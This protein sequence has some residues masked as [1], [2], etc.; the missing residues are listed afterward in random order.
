MDNAIDLASAY[1]HVHGYVTVAEYPIICPA[2]DAG[3]S[4]AVPRLTPNS[5]LKYY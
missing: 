3:A 4:G 5:W 1:L 2:H